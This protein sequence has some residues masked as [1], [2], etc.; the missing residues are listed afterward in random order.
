M[1]GNSRCSL[2]LQKQLWRLHWELWEG[3]PTPRVTLARDLSLS[4]SRFPSLPTDEA[5]IGRCLGPRHPRW[6]VSLR[7]PAQSERTGGGSPGPGGCAGVGEGSTAGPTCG[8][9]RRD[10]RVRS[11]SSAF[12]AVLCLCSLPSSGQLRPPLLRQR[13]GQ[14]QRKH[15]PVQPPGGHAGG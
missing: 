11:C 12:P 15:G 13:G 7:S 6:C 4:G 10:Q 5:E 9:R 1:N 3:V 8:A 2:L 14:H